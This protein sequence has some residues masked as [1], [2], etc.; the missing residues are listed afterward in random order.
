MKKIRPRVPIGL[1][2]AVVVLLILGAVA[3]PVTRSLFTEQQLSTNVI[4]SAIPFV[5]IFAAIVL[6][7]ITLVAF[8]ASLLNHNISPEVYRPIELIII[9]GIVLGVIGMFQPWF[10]TAYQIGFF[11]LLFSTL[12]FIMWSHVIPKGVHHTEE[13]GGVSIS[14]FEQTHSG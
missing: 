2:I 9:G 14:E 8:V 12:G 7:F 11:V 1:P 3:G 5:L 13:I 4:L 6:S 10:F